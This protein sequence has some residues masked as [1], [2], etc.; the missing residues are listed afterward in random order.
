MPRVSVV[1]A[2]YNGER[3]LRQAVDSILSQTYTDFEFIIID[4]GSTDGTAEI[5][6]GYADP[7]LRVLTQQNMGLVKSLNRGVGMARG[8]YVARMDADDI[9]LARRLELQVRCLDAH[10][11]TGALG[12][13]AIEIDEKDRAIRRHDHHPDSHTI[14]RALLEGSTP[15]CHGS[16]MFRK[17]CFENVGGYR[18]RFRHAEDYDLWLRMIERYD[19]DNLPE[20]LYQHRLVLDSVSSRHFMQQ[21]RGAAFALECAQRR[22]EG[23]PEPSTPPADSPPTR[24]EL[25][26]YHWHLGMA[27]LD[28]NRLDEARAE[29]RHA[30]LNSPLDPYFWYFYVGSLVGKSFIHEALPLAQ[31]IVRLL[32]WLRKD[33]LSPFRR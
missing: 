1:M 29:F 28:L 11:H 14:E 18:E 30:V 19:I 32:P 27:L 26:E 12:T 16:V 21:K 23:L 24:R 7:R 20:I 9:S 33:P 3:F 22:R 15:L 6:R 13:G 5:V 2:V 10:R 4:D 17:A 31:G 25:G 8:G